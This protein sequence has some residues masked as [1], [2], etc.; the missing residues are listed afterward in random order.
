MENINEME[1]APAASYTIKYKVDDL[2][3]KG[4]ETVHSSMRIPFLAFL[5][6]DGFLVH[7]RKSDFD[8]FITNT[9]V[10]SKKGLA[11]IDLVHEKREPIQIKVNG[12]MCKEAKK[13]Y[14]VFL[15]M[16]L[17]HGHLFISQLNKQMKFI[18]SAA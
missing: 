12:L 4:T 6:N 13:R 17:K 8:L 16:Y 3:P 18:K 2:T 7:A 10:K 14:A 5:F 9:P 1:A 11:E 15:K